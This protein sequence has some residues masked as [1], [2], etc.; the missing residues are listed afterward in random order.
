MK[1]LVKSYSQYINEDYSK[2]IEPK[3]GKE[4][5]PKREFAMTTQVQDSIRQ[6]CKDALHNEAIKYDE[7]DNHDHTYPGYM[8]EC[9]DYIAECM[10]EGVEIWKGSKNTAGGTF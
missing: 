4:I 2:D 1:K 9:L 5:N 7:D 10:N 6:F 8:Q 3:S